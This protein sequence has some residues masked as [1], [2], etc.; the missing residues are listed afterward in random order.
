M[1]TVEQITKRLKDESNINVCYN[2]G[3]SISTISNLKNGK[4]KRISH[5]TNLVLDKY[6]NNKEVSQ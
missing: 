6:F 5:L 2:T 1:I 4:T 3:L